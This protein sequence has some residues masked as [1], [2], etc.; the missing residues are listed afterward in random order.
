MTSKMTFYGTIKNAAISIFSSFLLVSLFP[1]RDMGVLAWIAIVPLL[2]VI[3]SRGQIEGF[4]LA[5]LCG[6]FFFLG[7]FD[8][9]RNIYNYRWHHHTILALYLGAYF[10]LFGMGVGHISNRLGQSAGLWAAPF[11]WVALEYIRSNF[12]FLALPWEL[13]GHSQYRYP[14]IM[15]LAAL[16]GTYGISFLIVLVNAGIA[17]LVL[18]LF[19]VF[20][21]R[22]SH[23]NCGM[24]SK[25]WALALL[26]SAV[27]CTALSLGYGH[28]AISKTLTGNPIDVAMVQ[29]NIEQGKKWDPKYAGE[30]I[31]IYEGLTLKAGLNLPELII[32]PETA[33]PGSISLNPEILDELNQIVLKTGTPLVFGSAQH[34]KFMKAEQERPHLVN[35]A[36]LMLPGN[37]KSDLQQ[38][39]KIRL[40]P[41]A[42][43]LPQKKIIP[44]KWI[45]VSSL[46]EYDS[47]QKFVVF[48]LPPY[49]FGV[50]ICWES[51][52]PD[53][54]RQFVRQGAQFMIN[55]TNEARFGKTAAPHQLLA[56]SVFRAVEN[57]IFII[58]C[59]NTGVSCIIDAQ[60]R[61]VKRL[62]DENGQD[63]FIRGILNG[64]IIPT[65][66]KTFYTR[67]GDLVPI[68]AI[69]VSLIFI[70]TAWSKPLA[71]RKITREL[72]GQ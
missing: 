53:L 5:Y 72:E 8:W 49:R 44:W 46:S 29:A 34:Q 16:L 40:L 45:N 31:Q 30:I 28:R 36:F 60:G 38:Y 2:L 69:A 4:L 21:S 1:D 6:I 64:T 71:E 24:A 10:G 63:L 35:S 13:I 67:N 18:V 12:F 39:D 66:S 54:V 65:E 56:M 57:G 59:A 42:E 26:S 50:A 55:I 3:S 68:L 48:E 58:R 37:K 19:P 52:F 22:R 9:I 33:T 20:Q 62:Q 14:T 15:Q 70:F 47:G 32:W 41:F 27:L 7:T 23:R 43:Y 17:C 11:I 51:I 61:I 25:K